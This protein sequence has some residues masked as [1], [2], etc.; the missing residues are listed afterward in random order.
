MPV[1]GTHRRIRRALGAAVTGAAVL[2]GGGAVAAA[3]AAPVNAPA[4]A[5]PALGA[6][7]AGQKTTWRLG[8]F[9]LPPAPLGSAH[10]NRPRIELTKPCE[11]CFITG[12]VPRLVYADGTHADMRTGVMLHHVGL[13]DPSRP[14]PA[15][16]RCSWGGPVFGSG[17]ERSPWFDLPAGYGFKV[18][19]GPWAG[20]A[21]MMNHGSVAREVYLEADVFT[22]PASTPGI[23]PVTPVMLS[24]ADACSTMEYSVAAGRTATSMT[25]TSPLTGRIVWGLGH[26]HPGGMGVVLS[27]ASTGARICAS[28]AGYGTPQGSHPDPLANMVTSMSTCSWDSLGTVRAGERLEV[29]SLYDAPRPLDGVMGIMTIAVHETSDLKGGTR[30]PASMRR[31]PD[32]KVPPGVGDDAAAGH[33]GHG[34]HGH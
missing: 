30:A 23:K 15:N 9:L 2:A 24:V 17:D 18:T 11:D 22:L 26:V 33:S 25:W 12:F 19:P 3:A 10:L 14:D 13:F 31:V 5:G 21:E 1:H 7:P 32:T 34:G 28:R 16:Q 8:P 20:F 29:T 4:A 27:N 6:R